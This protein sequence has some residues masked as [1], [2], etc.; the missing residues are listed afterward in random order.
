MFPQ[1]SLDCDA[2]CYDPFR[3]YLDYDINY[4]GDGWGPSNFTELINNISS[5]I[6]IN[7]MRIYPNPFSNLLTI[8]GLPN[9]DLTI[10]IY[11]IHSR[12]IY[13]DNQ[14]LAHSI[15]INT[16]YINPGLY[17][18][19]VRDIDSGQTITGKIIVKK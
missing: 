6:D 7:Q 8:D 1:R 16:A 12:L 19:R 17:L 4:W 15:T 11:D 14:Y 13:Q 5:G 2:Q 3:G 10:E 9:K 18:L